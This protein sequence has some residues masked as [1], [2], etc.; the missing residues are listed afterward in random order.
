M[1]ITFL[2]PFW[3]FF[4]IPRHHTLSDCTHLVLPSSVPSQELES[5]RFQMID[6]YSPSLFQQFKRTE[7]VIPKHHI[8]SYIH[9]QRYEQSSF[10]RYMSY[11]EYCLLEEKIGNIAWSYLGD[12]SP[13]HHWLLRVDPFFLHGESIKSFLNQDIVE[14]TCWVTPS[15][16]IGDPDY[17]VTK[18]ENNGFAM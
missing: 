1:K 9:Y 15:I 13:D 3:G 14:R 16:E 6:L 4:H 10:P 11:A 7:K 2:S 12:V 18:I 8:Y 5:S 17:V